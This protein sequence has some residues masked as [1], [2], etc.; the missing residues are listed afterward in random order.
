MSNDHTIQDED[1][2]LL[3]PLRLRSTFSVFKTWKPTEKELDG[4]SIPVMLTPNADEWMPYCTSYAE[5]EDTLINKKGELRPPEYVQKTLVDDY[6]LST[7][8]SVLGMDIDIDRSNDQAV[9]SAFRSQ[10]V[11]FTE[12]TKWLETKM[13]DAAALSEIPFSLDWKPAYDPMPV[14]QD[15]VGIVLSLVSNTLD[16]HSF[17]DALVSNAAASNFKMSIGA[18]SILPPEQDDDLWETGEPWHVT[19][20]I[21]D[22]EI[23]LLI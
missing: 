5:N 17:Y 11:E 23:W 10:D 13:S 3:I 20:N 12:E 8:D 18:T 9:I 16:P 21:S 15:Q 7:I 6:D 2:G 1:S 4:S 22:L 19:V 14:A